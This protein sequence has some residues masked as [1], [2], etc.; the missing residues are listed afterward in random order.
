[1][2]SQG[3]DGFVFLS[4][5]VNAQVALEQLP[6]A[7]AVRE[8]EEAE[9]QCSMRGGRMSSYYMFWYRQNLQSS[10]TWIYREGD[11]YGEGF[12]DR[13]QGIV[14]SSDNRFAL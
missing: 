1:I 3:D 4:T 6:G 14:Q 13:F 2:H 8:G 11:K 10:L 12:R 7:L 5:A 9:F